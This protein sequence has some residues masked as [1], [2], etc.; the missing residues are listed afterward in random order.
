MTE[1]WRPPEGPRHA[2]PVRVRVPA[3]INL[4]LHVGDLRPDHFHELSTVYHA[5]SLY[6]EL[7]AR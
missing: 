5:I 3:K 1:A 7:T 6:D 2:G 4:H